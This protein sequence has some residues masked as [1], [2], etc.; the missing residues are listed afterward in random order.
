V[1]WLRSQIKAPVLTN[2]PCGHVET[3]VVLPVGAKVSLS[4]EDRDALLYWGHQH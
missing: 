4:V 3:K 2:L 1:D